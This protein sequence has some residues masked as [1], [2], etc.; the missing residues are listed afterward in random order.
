MRSNRFRT[1]R[2]PTIFFAFK[3]ECNPIPCTSLQPSFVSCFS[4]PPKSIRKHAASPS[5]R[6]MGQAVLPRADRWSPFVPKTA[7]KEPRASGRASGTGLKDRLAVS[8][9]AGWRGIVA[10]NRTVAHRSSNVPSART[11]VRARLA[12][13]GQGFTLARGKAVVV[14]IF[15]TDP[16]V[17][18]RQEC[19]HGIREVFPR[20]GSVR[21]RLMPGHFGGTAKYG[22]ERPLP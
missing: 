13:Q 3:L 20:P 2:R 17:T 9:S 6:S 14:Y 5:K 12:N 19:T 16:A 4:S 8:R 18:M 22:A 10:W 7:D 15:P 21:L 1:L 11:T